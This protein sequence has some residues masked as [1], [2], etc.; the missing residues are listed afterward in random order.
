MVSSYK[1]EKHGN[2]RTGNQG[3]FLP[4]NPEPLQRQV[5]PPQIQSNIPAIF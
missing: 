4:Q 5:I 2:K 1:G 3:G